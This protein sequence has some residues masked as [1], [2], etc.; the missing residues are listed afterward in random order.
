MS[1]RE[2][3]PSSYQL[4]PWDFL[5]SEDPVVSAERV[6]TPPAPSRDSHPATPACGSSRQPEPNIVVPVVGC[7]CCGWPNGSCSNCCSNRRH[8]S[9][10]LPVPSSVP[11]KNQRT[12]Y[13]FPQTPGVPMLQVGDPASDRLR[14]FF[15]F[16]QSHRHNPLHLA[17][18]SAR[19]F[20]I[21]LPDPYP[22][23]QDAKPRKLAPG[24]SRRSAS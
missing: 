9:P 6:W 4:P 20:E 17:Q 5:Y 21:L 22:I 16:H 10:G 13:L 24:E 11:G 2:P 14:D 15:N 23:R 19:A 1:W 12:E 3:S 8:G 18:A 7:C